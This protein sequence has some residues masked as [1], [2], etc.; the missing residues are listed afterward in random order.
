MDLIQITDAYEHSHMPWVAHNYKGHIIF[1]FCLRLN[2]VWKV[3]YAFEDG[4]IHRLYTG[5]SES[6]YECNPVASYNYAEQ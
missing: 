6:A 2:D 5:L 1:V 4:I 3:H